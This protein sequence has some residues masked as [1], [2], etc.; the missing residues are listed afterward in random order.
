[1]GTQFEDYLTQVAELRSQE[2][3]LVS[4]SSHARRL[5]ARTVSEAKDAGVPVLSLMAAGGWA[6]RKSVYDLIAT[7]KEG[8]GAA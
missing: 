4:M 7:L 1:M 3:R 6:T 5:L 2:K 8:D